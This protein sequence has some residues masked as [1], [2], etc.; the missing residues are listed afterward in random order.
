VRKS[1]HKG[2]K[3]NPVLFLNRHAATRG[4]LLNRPLRRDYITAC[5]WFHSGLIDRTKTLDIGVPYWSLDPIPRIREVGTFSE[6][7]DATGEDILRESMAR[8]RNIQVLWSGGIDSTVALISLS[9]AAFN[10]ALRTRIQVVCSAH[11]IQEYPEFFHRHISGRFSCLVTTQPIGM[12]L[13][14]SKLIVTGEH[15]DQLFGS[16]KLKNLVENGL[17]LRPHRSS[18]AELL[19]ADCGSAE[20]AERMLRYLEPQIEAAPVSID[21]VF[22]YFW[23]VNFSLKWQHVALR[24]AVFRSTRVWPTYFALRHFF[25]G[26]AFQRWA[27]TNSKLRKLREWS[28]YKSPAKAFIFAF[29]GDKAYYKSKA[30]EPSLQNVLVDRGQRGRQRVR[31]SWCFGKKPRFRYFLPRTALPERRESESTTNRS[32]NT[33]QLGAR[34]TLES[35]DEIHGSSRVMR[36]AQ[37]TA[38]NRPRPN[39]K[40]SEVRLHAA[41]GEIN[42]R[43]A[44][45]TSAIISSDL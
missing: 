19:V 45:Q 25:R 39:L 8:N 34:R 24:L 37:K 23:W 4:W 7:A 42:S 18:M 26:K 13:D 40:R 9:K 5:R 1:G 28:L 10:C 31:V 15:G 3:L 21:T 20:A 27:L 36:R 41:D 38:S 17:A 11:S 30:K 22:D 43:T 44:K 29:T 33:K 35:E 32:G 14:D 16:V 2:H 12:V 6:I